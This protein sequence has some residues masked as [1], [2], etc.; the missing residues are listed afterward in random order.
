MYIFFIYFIAIDLFV[1]MIIDKLAFPHINKKRRSSYS[2]PED[3]YYEKVFKKNFP[4]LSEYYFVFIVFPIFYFILNFI[5][6]KNIYLVNIQSL[7][8]IIWVSL[9]ALII[10]AFLYS[11]VFEGFY[12]MDSEMKRLRPNIGLYL[13]IFIISVSF[14]CSIAV[15]HFLNSALDF[16]KAEEKIVDIYNTGMTFTERIGK[17]RH[18]DGE[19]VY[20]QHYNVYFS[21]EIGGIGSFEVSQS[22]FG[23]YRK[24]DRVKL[25]IKKGFLGMP[26]ISKERIIIKREDYE[27]EEAE[28][29][30]PKNIDDIVNSLINNMVKCPAGSYIM[31]RP[32]DSDKHRV[33]FTK[34]FFI[35]KYE[36]TQK[37]YSLIMRDNPSKFNDDNNPVENVNWRKAKTFCE[38]L[39][40]YGKTLP[41]GYQFGLPTEAQW[42]YACRAGTDTNLNSGKDVNPNKNNICPNLNEVGW[43]RGN[44]DNKTHLVGQ[45]KP[46]AWGIYDMHGNVAEWCRDY[47]TD[48]YSGLDEIDP[49]GPSSKE[50]LNDSHVVRGG[51][52][53]VNSYT[54]PV[55]CCTS[56]YRTSFDENWLDCYIG[57]RL[58]LV[59]ND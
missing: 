32:Y 9:I 27:K 37:E 20:K 45:K 6:N 34:P 3:I 5:W 10:F 46:N 36:V 50:G 17:N 49:T 28:K 33:T 12:G 55:D 2:S 48:S 42:E 44:A 8:P 30:I 54:N 22:E 25:F 51:G 13:I 7:I 52:F 11:K 21:P 26:Y 16:F 18:G 38:L 57:F 35:G 58:A 43:Y 23:N 40:K 59:S 1:L 41:A 29:N 56:F 4:F 19:K 24:G 53:W 15:A 31:G 14:L 39:N 47:Y